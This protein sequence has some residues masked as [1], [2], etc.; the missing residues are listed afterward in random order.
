L[1]IN[2][3]SEQYRV[4]VKKDCGEV[5]APGTCGHVFEYGKGRFGIFLEDNAPAK[6]SKAKALLCP[7]TGSSGSWIYP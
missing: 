1:T 5:T 7:Q 3:L 2:E 4:R 6:T